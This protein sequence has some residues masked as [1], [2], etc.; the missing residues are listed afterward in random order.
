MLAADL[1]QIQDRYPELNWVMEPEAKRLLRRGGLPVPRYRWS[2]TESEALAA[3][4]EIGYPVVAKVVSP[5]VVHKSDVGGVVTGIPDST[6]LSKVYARLSPFEGFQGLLVEETVTGVELIVGA[7]HDFQFGPVILMGIGGTSVE[8]YQDVAIR[9]APLDTS[10]VDAMWCELKG[11]P[12]LE[13]Y[14][15]TAPVNR[16]A[17]TALLLKFS[18][19]VMALGEAVES[20]DLNPVMCGPEAC[21]VADARI[22]LAC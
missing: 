21:N 7:K 6:A 17:L 20:I 10:D 16:A 12:L 22:M 3:A 13:G 4:E 5:Q 9:M 8:I 18:D 14:R 1:A 19:V 2:G 11:R 15:G